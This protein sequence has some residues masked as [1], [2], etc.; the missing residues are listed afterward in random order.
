DFKQ[1]SMESLITVIKLYF[2][3]MDEMQDEVVLMYQEAKSLKGDTKEYVLQKE[4]DMVSM[5]KWVIVTCVPE[6]MTAQDAELLANNIFVQGQMWGF[7][8]WVLQKQ[9]TLEEYIDRQ[10]YYLKQAL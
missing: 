9:F 4:R 3:L 5:L 10:I 6:E 1:P 7:R 8:R 2:R